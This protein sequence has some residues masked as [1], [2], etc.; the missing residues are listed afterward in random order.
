MKGEREV[1]EFVDGEVWVEGRGEG[2]QNINTKHIGIREKATE[3]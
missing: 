1:G 3:K 2:E